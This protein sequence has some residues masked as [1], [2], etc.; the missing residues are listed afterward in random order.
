MA[1]AKVSYPKWMA[2]FVTDNFT[3]NIIFSIL[4]MVIFG[5]FIVFTNKTR[6]CLITNDDD[7]NVS[8]PDAFFIGGAWA[9]GVLGE[10]F[11]VVLLILSAIG[12]ANAGA[13]KLKAEKLKVEL[14]AA[15]ELAAEKG[16]KLGKLGGI[17]S[18]GKRRRR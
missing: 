10:C 8:N 2:K 15:K 14:K 7:F 11:A 12:L 9:L 4:L 5:F 16:G 13:E 17:G 1:G 18:F 3:V 6:E